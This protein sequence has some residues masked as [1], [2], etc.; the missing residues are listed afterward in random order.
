MTTTGPVD[1]IRA[2]LPFAT[3]P[4]AGASPFG[5]NRDL[6]VIERYLRR[7]PAHRSGEHC[8]NC[9][10]WIPAEYDPHRCIFGGHP[11][12]SSDTDGDV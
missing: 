11:R 9:R 4:V 10:R 12:I 3:N 1:A 5:R 8:P 7:F 2:E 6:D